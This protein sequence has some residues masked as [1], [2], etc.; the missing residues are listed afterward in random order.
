LTNKLYPQVHAGEK[1]E[2]NWKKKDYLIACCDCHLVHRFRFIV[3]GDKLRIRAWR[4]NRRTSSLRRYRGIPISE[5]N[6]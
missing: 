5:R 6:K 2:L 4:D 1:V 3:S